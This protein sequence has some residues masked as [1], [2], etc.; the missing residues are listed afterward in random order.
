MIKKIVLA[1]YLCILFLGINAEEKKEVSLDLYGYLRYDMYSDTYKGGNAVSDEFYTLPNYIGVDAAGKDKNEQLSANMLAVMS[2]FG[3]NIKGPDAFNAKTSAKIETDFLGNPGSM[4]LVLRIRHAYIKLDWNKSSLLA[5]Q[6]W[7]PFFGGKSYPKVVNINTGAPF[8]P[9]NRSPQLTYTY[10]A[11][12]IKLLASAVYEF[13]Y[14][15]TG[16]DG[17]TDQYSRNAVVPEM[18]LGVAFDKNNIN[19]GAMASYKT[20]NPRM[21]NDSNYISTQ[22]ISSINYMLY[23]QYK[24][25]KLEING[26]GVYGGNMA[27]MIMPGGYAVSGYNDEPGQETYTNYNYLTTFANAVYGSKLKVG[28]FVGYAKNMGSAKELYNFGADENDIQIRQWGRFLNIS[29]FYR[30]SASLIYTVKNISLL[31]EYELTTANYGT[32]VQHLSDGLYD[33]SHS[34]TNSRINLAMI[35]TF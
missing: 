9:F 21:L 16:P 11:G 26:T 29:D 14:A 23:L 5:G 13:Q 3:F 17:F 30:A 27:H 8:Q 7:H 1:C 2:R 6:T 4:P 28:A 35:Y 20:L 15:S 19:I 12:A 34:A 10:N 31:G 24:K 32:G 22:T 25:G 33:A 18:V